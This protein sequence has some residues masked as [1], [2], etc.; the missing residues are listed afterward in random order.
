MELFWLAT[1]PI[2]SRDHWY[3][4]IKSCYVPFSTSAQR[5][6]QLF[7]SFLKVRTKSVASVVHK[8]V[9]FFAIIS[10]VR[11]FACACQPNHNRSQFPLMLS[12]VKIAKQYAHCWKIMKELFIKG[13]LIN[14]PTFSNLKSKSIFA[15]KYKKTDFSIRP[16]L[17]DFQT[18]HA[19]YIFGFAFGD[20]DF[21]SCGGLPSSFANCL[22]CV[23]PHN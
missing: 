23:K 5:L 20:E 6:N 15:L 22:E 7:G 9:S 21:F 17:D 19:K 3:H 8:P 18:L 4:G 1:E 14:F 12:F 11:F 13:F 10:A 2:H 16:F